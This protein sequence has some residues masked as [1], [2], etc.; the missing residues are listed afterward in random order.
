MKFK[1]KKIKIKFNFLILLNYYKVFL[2]VIFIVSFSLLGLFL[3]KNFYLTITHSE[4][5]ITLSSEVASETLDK[6]SFEKTIL[7][8]EKKGRKTTIDWNNVKDPF[9]Y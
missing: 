3:Y 2:T 7:I 9:L 4:E 1:M 8:I 6:D 5:I